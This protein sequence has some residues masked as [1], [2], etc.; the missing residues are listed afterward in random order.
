[1]KFTVLGA[2]GYIGSRLVAYL[3]TQGYECFAP[4]R[5][6]PL[7]FSGSLGHVIYCIGLTADF[8]YRPYDTVRAHVSVLA[9]VLE[10][11]HYDSFLYLSSTRI[12]AHSTT[13]TEDTLLQAN[14]LFSGDL[15]NLTKMTGEAL[16]LALPSEK[17]RI[18]RLSNVYGG[19]WD[20][21]NFLVSVMRDAL[22]KRSV[23]LQ[24]S[25]T[26][27]KDYVHIDDVVRMLPVIAMTGQ[28]R[29]YNVASG[30]NVSNQDLLA[31]IK[32][33]TG[34]AVE[35]APHAPT[36]KFPL[37]SIERLRAEFGFDASKIDQTLNQMMVQPSHG[38]R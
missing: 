4:S 27:E 17:I 31:I 20:S 8:R 38:L 25:A 30:V 11:N 37:I 14:P 12:Y 26:S 16:C 22:G 15:Y 35:Y 23:L 32:R 34:C 9:E 1:M 29:L 2:G 24:T 33:L 3:E 19:E 5:D 18:V 7:T 36:V 21:E 6:A 28:H 13:A 10:K